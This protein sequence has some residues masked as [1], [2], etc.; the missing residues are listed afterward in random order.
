MEQLGEITVEGAASSAPAAA[1][2]PQLI[3]PTPGEVAITRPNGRVQT[4]AEEDLSDAIAQGD[5]PATSAEYTNAKMGAF[6]PVASGLTETGRTAT[7]G[8]SDVALVEGDRLIEGDAEAERM[9]GALR[10]MR[11]VNPGANTAGIV[12]GSLLPLAFGAPPAGGA[13]EGAGLLARAGARVVQAA[14]RALAEGALIGAGQ[15]LTEDY[16]GNH[17]MVAQ[18]YLASSLK[19]GLMALV[20][21]GGMSAGLGAAGDK[22]AAL[23]GRTVEAIEH[24]VEGGP[25]RALGK[26]GESARGK[27]ILQR[28]IDMAE[29]QAAKG[30][31]PSASLAGSEMQKLGAT[32][33]AQQTRIRRI[34]RTLLDE[35]ITTPGA[36]KA[37][38][39]QRLTARASEVGEELGS[40]RRSFDRA[41]A[42]PSAETIMRRVEAE[43]L[44][45]LVARAFTGPEQA[46]VM[47]V[48]RELG[49]RLGASVDDAGKVIFK[50]PVVDS[51][52]TLHKLR[53]ELDAKLKWDKGIPPPTPAL[54]ELRAIRGILEDEFEEAASR[55]AAELGEE[56]ASR[57]NVAK[58]LYADLKTAE[59]W[60]TKGAAR[61]AQN[62]AISLTDT[63]MAGAAIASGHPMG[64]L[65][66]V[67]NKAVRTYGNQVAATVLDRATRIEGIQRAAMAFDEK[68]DRAVHAFFGRGKALPA[69]ARS[70]RVS[71]EAA[72]ALRDAARSPSQLA[73]RAAS[74]VASM[75]LSDVAP[76]TSRAM[77]STFMRA[78]TWLAAKLPAEPPPR[79]LAFGSSK[80]RPVG[81]RAQKE[82][83]NAF[84]ALDADAF[85]DDLARGRVDRQA[86]EAMKFINPDLYDHVVGKLRQFGME[87]RPDLTRQQAVALSIVTGTPLTPLMK[88]E[89]IA[90][91]QKAYEQDTPPPNDPSAP[92]ATEKKQMGP[93]GPP[94]G[95][96]HSSRA[97]ASG[98]DKM[99]A[100][101]GQ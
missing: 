84:R 43:V 53:R 76:Q 59:K 14:P 51:F 74:A 68:L 28:G 4:V 96:A 100:S 86:L 3:R 56:T 99:E 90:G 10:E 49:D 67:A 78:G 62:R 41:E 15:Q 69:A 25:Y 57:Y 21:G 5:K 71:P 16:L 73:D 26:V 55:A 34:G 93:G 89:T 64:L 33:E 23:R 2:V 70:E 72:R 37:V 20:I 29:E 35:G 79:A 40:L 81:P 19:G 82:I 85:V 97:F 31:M 80:P 47:P 61:D 98:T 39:A 66:P 22:L 36:T 11:E 92:G 42:R 9:R 8:L 45:P 32:A 18:K 46:A 95:R 63:I 30:A 88:P 75:G 6:G 101:N 17:E 94:P 1:P 13:I 65:A 83:D 44:D 87:N 60:A 54:K 24:A 50:S 58:A 77:V 91:F 38:Q 27:G 48:V 52:E 7:F 12:A